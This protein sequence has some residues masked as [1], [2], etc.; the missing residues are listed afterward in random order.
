MVYTIK[1]EPRVRAKSLS[2]DSM[3]QE[4]FEG[5]YSAVINAALANVFND[6]TDQSIIDRLY[7]FFS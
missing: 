3:E 5:V 4:E 2:F 7:S 6:T 1:G